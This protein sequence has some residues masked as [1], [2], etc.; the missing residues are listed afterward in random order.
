[1]SEARTTIHDL[2]DEARAGVERPSPEEAHA[3]AG[4]G[5]LLV[6]IRSERQRAEQGVVPGALWFPRNVLEWRADPD[7]GASDPRLARPDAEVILF[8]AEGYASSLAAATLRRLGFAHATDMAG[9]FQAWLAAGLPVEAPTGA[10]G[11]LAPRP[12]AG[13]SGGSA[14]G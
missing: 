14:R 2:L 7:S 10:G 9:G 4:R 12:P 8:C 13:T 5:A 6:D 11:D 1:M 3:A